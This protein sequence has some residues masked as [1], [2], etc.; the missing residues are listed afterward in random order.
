MQTIASVQQVVEDPLWA[1]RLLQ[2][3]SSLDAAPMVGQEVGQEVTFGVHS[4]R[5]NNFI[6]WRLLGKTP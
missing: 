2:D 3:M 5:V 6:F 1:P 4:C